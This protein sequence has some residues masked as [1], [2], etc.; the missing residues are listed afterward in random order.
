MKKIF[1]DG[2]EGTTGL[3]IFK[4]LSNHPFIEI[5][6]IDNSKRKN[7]SERKKLMNSADLI[8]LCLPDNVAKQTVNMIANEIENDPIIIDASTA[9]RTNKDWIYGLPEMSLKQ[10]NSISNAKKISI[11]GCYACGATI[12]LYPLMQKS[13]IQPEILLTINAISGY[14]G[15]GKSLI[16]YFKEQEVEPFFYYGLDLN[17]KHLPEIKYHNKLKNMPIFI[18]SVSKFYQ[19]M[20]VNVPLHRANINKNYTFS[21]IEE[22]FKDFYKDSNFVK[23]TRHKNSFSKNLFF[24]PDKVTNTNN[25]FINFFKNENNNQLLIS[26]NFDN[27]G[28]GASSNAIQC[29]NIVFGFEEDVSLKNVY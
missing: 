12:I 24:R 19:G 6:K 10:K 21:D 3:Q 16:N 2:E 26:S 22:E 13:I 1:I 29:M 27:L 4:K 23:I 25:L 18:P 20:I 11:P 8:F 9:H 17:H 5:L 7:I 14:S 28:K 15:G